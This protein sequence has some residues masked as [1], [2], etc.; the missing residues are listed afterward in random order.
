MVKAERFCPFLFHPRRQLKQV[1]NNIIAITIV[2]RWPLVSNMYIILLKFNWSSFFWFR[3]VLFCFCF[4]SNL[5]NGWWFRESLTRARARARTPHT[6][7]N[8][9]RREM[10]SY[11]CP[12]PV[13]THLLFTGHGG[14]LKAV[15]SQ[16]AYAQFLKCTCS[17][18]LVH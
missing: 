7:Y 16:S 17:N 2:G 13:R 3:F 10:I 11:R 5:S 6:D 18:D 4:H 1:Y 15:Q 12:C 8:S 9:E 14:I